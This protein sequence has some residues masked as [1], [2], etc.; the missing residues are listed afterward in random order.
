MIPFVVF[1]VGQQK[2]ANTLAPD[3][4]RI[5]RLNSGYIENESTSSGVSD[6]LAQVTGV[7]GLEQTHRNFAENALAQLVKT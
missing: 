2:S 5:V 1:S 3:D 7:L 6:K 4:I